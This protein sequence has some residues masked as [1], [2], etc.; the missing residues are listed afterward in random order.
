MGVFDITQESYATKNI[1]ITQERGTFF[2]IEMNVST[3]ITL[4]VSMRNNRNRIKDAYDDDYVKHY[5]AE[6]TLVKLDGNAKT[7]TDYLGVAE[8]IIIEGGRAV[9][10]GVSIWDYCDSIDQEMCNYAGTFYTKDGDIDEKI[11]ECTGEYD[12]MVLQRVDVEECY[13]GHKFGLQAAKRI[14]EHFGTNCG[15]IAISPYYMDEKD[16]DWVLNYLSEGKLVQA[17]YCDIPC[18]KYLPGERGYNAEM[19]YDI[20]RDGLSMGLY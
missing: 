12:V 5:R 7:T 18:L 10:D 3:K 19:A 13:R 15:I 1:K 6:L 2:E 8:Y 4:P 11:R 9:N 16:K 20:E 17:G 14:F